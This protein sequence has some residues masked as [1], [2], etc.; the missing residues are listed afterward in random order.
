MI[1]KLFLFGE[2][3]LFALVQ[4]PADFNLKEGDIFNYEG[5]KYKI[6]VFIRT[7]FLIE[8]DA[9]GRQKS[10][11]IPKPNEHIPELIITEIPQL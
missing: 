8:F 10:Q 1:Y 5:K 2:K 3:Q 6:L 4:I 7:A 11:P 9:E